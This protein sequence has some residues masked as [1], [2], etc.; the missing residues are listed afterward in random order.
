MKAANEAYSSDLLLFMSELL[1]VLFMS[2]DVYK[3]LNA[4]N[5]SETHWRNWI[6]LCLPKTVMYV[7]NQ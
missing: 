5:I 3:P 4:D 1:I 6:T 2:E 7:F